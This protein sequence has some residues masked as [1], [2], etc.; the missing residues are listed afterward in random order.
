VRTAIDSNVF[1]AIWSGEASAAPA[2]DKLGAAKMDGAL[3]ISPF[4]FAEL[5][6][7]PGATESH[8]RGFLERTGV[9]IDYRLQEAVWD[10]TGRRFAR[11][12]I[13]RRQSF[14]KSPRRLLA[15]FLIGA[16]ALVQADRLF[17]FD[18]TV[19]QQDFPEVKLLWGLA[20][21]R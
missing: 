9:A 6:A 17:T 13:R 7:Y 1:S 4:V 10:E 8:V 14:G 16:H 15:D 2:A 18:P 3:L 12:A 11:Y 5:L 19:Y 21:S 20:P